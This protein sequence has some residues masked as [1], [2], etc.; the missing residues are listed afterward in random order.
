MFT[1]FL[2]LIFKWLNSLRF[3]EEIF[4]LHKTITKTLKQ[5]KNRIK[6][7]GIIK[8]LIFIVQM[9]ESAGEDEYVYKMKS[10]EKS[11]AVVP[12]S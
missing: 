1:S 10:N 9:D 7:H 5:N 2:K 12:G 11:R 4:Q 6:P 3:I 8:I